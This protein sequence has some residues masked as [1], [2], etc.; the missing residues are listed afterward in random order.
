L[1]ALFHP[2]SLLAGY[3]LGYLGILI[4]VYVYSTT[5][6]KHVLKVLRDNGYPLQ[7]IK[8]CDNWRRYKNK[9]LSSSHENMNATQKS[10][11]SPSYVVLPY[12]NFL[13]VSLIFEKG[14]FMQL[15]V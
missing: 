9:E 7:F 15:L 10:T 3:V 14:D 5:E 4:I 2:E 1:Q 12:T 11:A 8:S 13:I 6:R